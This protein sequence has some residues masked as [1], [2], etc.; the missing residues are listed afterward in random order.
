[1]KRQA[2][3]DLLKCFLEKQQ[4]QDI[5]LKKELV[6]LLAY[7]VAKGHFS[8]PNTVF[9]VEEWRAFGD[10][11][12][13]AVI[14]E[15]KTAKK[16]SRP[17]RA[18]INSLLQHQAEQSVAQKVKQLLSPK[19]SEFGAVGGHVGQKEPPEDMIQLGQRQVLLPPS[20]ANVVILT[21]S[22]MPKPLLPAVPVIT[23]PSNP[24]LA[25]AQDEDSLTPG[26][27]GE[28]GEEAAT[29]HH[30]E[31]AAVAPK[32]KL[33]PRSGS[34]PAPKGECAKRWRD[35]YKD[36]VL[37]GDTEAAHILG[38]TVSQ[39]FPVTFTQEQGPNGLHLVGTITALDWKVVSQLRATVNETG[40]HGEPAKQML[41]YI[42]SSGIL[43]PTDI[44]TIMKMILTQSQQLLWQAHWHELCVHSALQQCAHGHPLFGATYD[45]LMGVGAFVSPDH[46]ATRG[47]Y[48]LREGMQLAL[49]ALGKV[50]M[51]T[52]M[53]TY[54]GIKQGRDEPFASFIDWVSTS[55]DQA[56]D[57][58]DWM[59]GA[60]LWQCIL[61]NCNPQTR[62]VLF[63]LPGDASIEQML[64]RM[65]WVPVGPQAM[66]VEAV[67][68]SVSA[69][70][71]LGEVLKRGQERQTQVLAA[72]VPLRLGAGGRGRTNNTPSCLTCFCCGTMGHLQR[73]CTQ[74][75]VWCPACRSDT[76]AA[77][78][79]RRGQ[80]NGQRSAQTSTLRPYTAG[81]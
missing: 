75:S 67:K 30:E 12:W 18:V 70:R 69:V 39:T 28:L 22:P 60:L 64:D 7:G 14:D 71:E 52:G 65:S 47:P 2:A 31:L 38:E 81:S 68:E 56:V 3:C 5:D 11:L 72:L 77:A 63:T 57:V 19:D 80:G 45:E 40:I 21:A 24:F 17:W 48:K 78:A 8:D 50:K 10:M 59:K 61:Q 37:A 54:M 25:E 73:D 46:Q 55:I 1:V 66:L 4:V 26:I 58:Q 6:G 51:T 53:P 79:C 16:L 76:H 42:W 49:E 44:R 9:C 29:Y 62:A 23:Q 34:R 74:P 27:E 43:L 32:P 36:A 20:T 13:S 41:N 15:D 35:I 33:K